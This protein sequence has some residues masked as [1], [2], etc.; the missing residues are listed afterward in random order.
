MRSMQVLYKHGRVSAH[1]ARKIILILMCGN[2]SQ[3]LGMIMNN[4]CIYIYYDQCILE[5]GCNCHLASLEAMLFFFF[6]LVHI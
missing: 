4:F 3:L 6:V 2:K 1:I 5:C